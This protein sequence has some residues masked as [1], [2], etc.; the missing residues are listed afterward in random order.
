MCKD[1][2][3]YTTLKSLKC[4][5]NTKTLRLGNARNMD[6]PTD[7]CYAN[8]FAVVALFKSANP[9]AKKLRDNLTI[10]EIMAINYETIK[11]PFYIAS[12]GNTFANPK[13]WKE[14]ANSE[15]ECG[16]AIGFDKEILFQRLDQLT[17][18]YTR[19]TRDK[20][21]SL[22]SFPKEVLNFRTIH[23]DSLLD[24]FN[25]ML[26]EFK[27]FYSFDVENNRNVYELWLDLVLTV[28]TGVIK[29]PEKYKEDGETRLVF[30]SDNRK[31]V[32][33]VTNEFETLLKSLGLFGDPKKEDGTTRYCFDFSS[34]CDSVL[35]PTIFLHNYSEEDVAELKI[36]LA[37]AGLSKTLLK[38]REGKIL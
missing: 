22:Q 28:L 19:N 33:Y 12:F 15:K 37:K 31:W 10:E 18:E 2:Y 5:I 11:S 32:P 3:H 14:Y 6:D 27:K 13:L 34:F 1:I 9:N 24:D 35:I 38:N 21:L 8:L 7:R 17:T 26:N 20:T 23:Y 16:A 29:H 30:Q 25:T 4:I 36:I